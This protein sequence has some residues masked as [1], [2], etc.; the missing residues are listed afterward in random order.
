MFPKEFLMEMIQ[1][2]IDEFEDIVADLNY[3]LFKAKDFK[4]TCLDVEVWFGELWIEIIEQKLTKAENSLIGWKILLNRVEGKKI[5][6]G[7][8]FQ[9][10]KRIPFESI[11]GQPQRREQDRLWYKCPLHNEETPSFMVDLKQN[12]FHCFGCSEHG[13]V[14]DL[15]MKINNVDIKQAITDLSEGRLIN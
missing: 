11:I 7:H 10:I 1:E 12:K 3:S 15:Y 13:D 4:A 6:A 14:I 8:D 2:K 5:K 9:M